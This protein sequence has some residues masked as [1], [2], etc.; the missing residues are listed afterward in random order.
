MKDKKALFPGI[1]TS[2]VGVILFLLAG[3][4]YWDSPSAFIRLILFI[5][6]ISGCAFILIGI[7]KIIRN[8]KAKK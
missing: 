5:I 1:Y 4:L 2:L 6:G 7:S 3:I 8:S